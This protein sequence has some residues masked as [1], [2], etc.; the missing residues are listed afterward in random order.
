MELDKVVEFIE[1][2]KQVPFYVWGT[3]AILIVVI[4]GDR[5]RWDKKARFPDN[6]IKGPGYVE[7]DCYRKKGMVLTVELSLGDEFSNKPIEIY[8]NNHL[9][10]TIPE[11]K[12]RWGMIKHKSDYTLPSPADGENIEIRSGGVTILSSTLH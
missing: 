3:I 7:V 5:K 10:A 6:G 4:F 12:T 11:N 1:L 8:F 2:V 9:A